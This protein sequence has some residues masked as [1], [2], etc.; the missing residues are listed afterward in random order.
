MDRLTTQHYSEMYLL[1]FQLNGEHFLL[2]NK[3][4]KALAVWPSYESLGLRIEQASSILD[5]VQPQAI[6]VTTDT[7][8]GIADL[9]FNRFIE[10]ITGAESTDRLRLREVE[11]LLGLPILR[12]K[13]EPYLVHTDRT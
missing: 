10:E 12:E 9:D 7:H 3:R 8:P 1:Y 11:G 4:N 6:R 2:M 13:I 5:E